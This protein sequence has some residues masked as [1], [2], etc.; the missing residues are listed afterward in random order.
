[1]YL[2]VTRLYF[3]LDI[4]TSTLNNDDDDDDELNV[5]IRFERQVRSKIKDFTELTVPNMT[6]KDFK[7]HFRLTRESIEVI[8]I[9]NAY[10]IYSYFYFIS[11]TRYLCNVLLFFFR[12]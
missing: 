5:F 12:F 10:L 2:K 8:H 11:Y 3:F 9:T 4:I 1:M 6:D 7:I